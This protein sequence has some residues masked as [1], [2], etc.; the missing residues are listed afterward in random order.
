MRNYI[1]IFIISLIKSFTLS[2]AECN[3]LQKSGKLQAQL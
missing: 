3:N 1:K 2:K